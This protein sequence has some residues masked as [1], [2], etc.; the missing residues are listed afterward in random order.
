MPSVLH[1]KVFILVFMTNKMSSLLVLNRFELICLLKQVL[2]H[3]FYIIP[4]TYILIFGKQAKADTNHILLRVLY[5]KLT[6]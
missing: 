5:H 4:D 6:T 1:Q 3:Y 2:C